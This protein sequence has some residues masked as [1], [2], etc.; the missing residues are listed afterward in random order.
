MEYREE[1]IGTRVQI[2][3]MYYLSEEIPEG[4]FYV[5][6]FISS[7]CAA[8]AIPLGLL[9][10]TNEIPDYEQGEW[11]NIEGEIQLTTVGERNFL[12]MTLESVTPIEQPANPLEYRSF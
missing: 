7:C 12:G 2:V 3:G 9:V 11:L 1:Y 8:D 5:F 10:E 4:Y 6:R